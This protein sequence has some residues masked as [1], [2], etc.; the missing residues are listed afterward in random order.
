VQLVVFER[1]V[2][3]AMRTKS[4]GRLIPLLAVA[5]LVTAVHSSDETPEAAYEAAQRYLDEWS[6]VAEEHPS[7]FWELYNVSEPIPLGDVIL[8]PPYKYYKVPEAKLLEYAQSSGEN[9]LAYATYISYGFPMTREGKFLGT[10]LV[11]KNEHP[12]GG[13]IVRVEHEYVYLGGHVSDSANE[14]RLMKLREQYATADGFQACRLNASA[15]GA[16]LVIE[17]DEGPVMIAPLTLVAA[18]ALQVESGRTRGDYPLI[19]MNEATPLIQNA[20][21]RFREAYE[22][23]QLDIERR[24]EGGE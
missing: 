9:L 21:D 24:R 14:Q 6:E 4:L 15:L 13:K 18:R 23:R 22:K 16:Y 3:D 8:E 1:K 7:A 11:G 17:S 19:P 20:A 2:C 10:I 5:L 12:R